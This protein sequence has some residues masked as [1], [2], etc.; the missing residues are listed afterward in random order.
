M[1]KAELV[2]QFA[3]MSF[4]F[5]H[6]CNYN[7]PNSVWVYGYMCTMF[8]CVITIS[9]R[10]L[11]ELNIEQHFCFLQG[12][13]TKRKATDKLYHLSH[14]QQLS[15][16][17]TGGVKE[18]HLADRMKTAALSAGSH[19][20]KQLR[21]IHYKNSLVKLCCDCSVRCE[22]QAHLRST[23]SAGFCGCRDPESTRC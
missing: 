11:Q 17:H 6:P 10:H 19:L 2:V 4:L 8:H 20:T 21:S 7:Q 1:L 23:V 14:W 13:K 3:K 9:R 12:G 15:G 5:H 16:C 18:K 22:H